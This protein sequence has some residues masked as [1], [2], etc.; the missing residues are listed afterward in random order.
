MYNITK[1]THA[2]QSKVSLMHTLEPIPVPYTVWLKSWKDHLPERTSL[3]IPL[4][5]TGV[6][7]PLI[8]QK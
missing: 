4:T 1:K 7:T 5:A 3:Q 2:I 8:A 6:Q